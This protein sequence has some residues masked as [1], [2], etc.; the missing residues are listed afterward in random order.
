MLEA[1]VRILSQCGTPEGSLP[2]TILYN[3]GWMLR[4]LLD[5]LAR[6]PQVRH[7]LSP[8]LGARWASEVLL[9]SRFLAQWRGDPR[10]ESFTH[11]DG[12]VGHFDVNS[13]RGDLQLR[14]GAKQ[15]LVIEAKM[16]SGLSAGTK[17]APAFDQAARNVACMAHLFAPTLPITHAA[18]YVLAPRAQVEAGVFGELVTRNSISAKVRQRC[19]VYEGSQ[20]EWYTER[21]SPFLEAVVLR[22]LS[23]EDAIDLLPNGPEV[24]GLRN[25]YAECL[26]FNLGRAVS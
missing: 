25:F 15:F 4:L 23:W 17:N 7:P 5:H 9:P 22:V 13:P 8:A 2:P 12:V 6:H 26:R 18:F 3:E 14:A 24:D 21:F 20:D 1:I 19:D 16:G 11:A 10:S